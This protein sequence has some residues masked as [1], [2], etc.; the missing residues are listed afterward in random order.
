MHITFVA[1]NF[2]GSDL[3]AE[4]QHYFD[5]HVAL[6]KSFPGVSLYVT[7]RFLAPG[8]AKP[9]HVRG[10]ILGF[11]S[12]AASAAAMGTDASMK[13]I[14]DSQQHL[15]DMRL[16]VFEAE[17]V[18]PFEK[19]KSGRPCFLW[20]VAFDFKPEAGDRETAERN[21]RARHVE[22]A[23]KMPGLKGYLIGRLDGERQRIALMAFENA[24]QFRAATASPA[25]MEGSKD[26][27]AT[28]TNLRLE[29]L[30]ARL[31]V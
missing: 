25:G 19:G 7:G 27:A 28:L 31:E 10:A 20:A 16:E 12:V 13:V 24:D 9:A 29:R 11:D 23:R 26:G 2:T 3:A 15:T 1:F 17:A 4:E 14:V 6:A 5:Y 18:V 21:Y 22:L 8:G 30:D